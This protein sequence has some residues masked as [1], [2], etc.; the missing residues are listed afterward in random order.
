MGRETTTRY[1]TFVFQPGGRNSVIPTE[2]S[3]FCV[4]PECWMHLIIG[5]KRLISGPFRQKKTDNRYIVS[6]IGPVLVWVRGFE[7]PAS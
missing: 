6:I 1:E 5:G 2:H 3:R 7:P 4:K